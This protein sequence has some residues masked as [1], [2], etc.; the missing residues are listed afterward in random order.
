M[1]KTLSEALG[2]LSPDLSQE[3]FGFDS[4][5]PAPLTVSEQYRALNSLGRTEDAEALRQQ[6]VF[7]ARAPYVLDQPRT[8]G[9]VAVDT[10]ASV[11]Q[12]VNSLATG[13]ASLTALIDPSNVAGIAA[14]QFG[15]LL[16]SD[17]V[18]AIGSNLQLPTAQALAE[19]A[20][21][22]NAVQD[23]ITPFQSEQTQ[24]AIQQTQNEI[25]LA[26]EEN[27]EE[28]S[29]AFDRELENLWDTGKAYINNP[30]AAI[31]L[32][33]QQIPQLLAGA[34]VGKLATVATRSQATAAATLQGEERI[35]A[36]IAANKARSTLAGR[37]QLA[38]ITSQE[39]G[40]AVSATASQILQTS[41]EDLEANS[42]AYREYIKQ[43]LSPENARELVALRGGELA[44]IIQAP[45][46]FSTGRVAAQFETQPFTAA[47]STIG[48]KVSDAAKNIGKELAEE[49]P[50][51]TTGQLAQN[52]GVQQT[53]DETQELTEGL[54][55]A[56][57]E[58]AVGA[59]T[60]TT[61]AQTPTVAKTVATQFIPVAG[62]AAY[63]VGKTGIQIPA[64]IIERFAERRRTTNQDAQNLQEDSNNASTQFEQ[65]ANQVDEVFASSGVG[66][67]TTSTVQPDS[68]TGDNVDIDNGNGG[69][70]ETTD[71]VSSVPT[72]TESNIFSEEGRNTIQAIADTNAPTARKLVDA[73]RTLDTLPK[74]ATE[75]RRAL[76]IYAADLVGE[77]QGEF[78][79]I[80]TQLTEGSGNTEQLTNQAN[81]IADLLN[82]ER[83]GNLVGQIDEM[84]VSDEEWDTVV[85]NL[86]EVT[87]ENINSEE[88][89][90]ALLTIKN[91]SVDTPT[92]VTPEQYDYILNH[93]TSLTPEQRST[94]ETK[95]EVAQAIFDSN[96]VRNN[97]RRESRAGFQSINE[98]A[99]NIFTAIR[100]NLPEVATQQLT[101]LRR[102]AETAQGRAAAHD[103]VASTL[104]RTPGAHTDEM[105]KV[106]GYFRLDNQGNI[107]RTSLQFVNVKSENGLNNLRA[108]QDDANAVTNAFNVLAAKYP[109][110]GATEITPHVPTWETLLQPTTQQNAVAEETIIEEPNVTTEESTN[111]EDTVEPVPEESEVET[112]TTP[113]TQPQ[114]EI[115][116]ETA[117][118]GDNETSDGETPIVRRESGISNAFSE[119]TQ[120]TEA[121]NT[122]TTAAERS[123]R[124][125]QLTKSFT[126]SE[127][128][129][130]LTPNFVD[131]LEVTYEDAPDDLE[132]LIDPNAEFTKEQR[133]GI[134][135]Y[136][137]N[138]RNMMN[139]MNERLAEFAK[140]N[141][142]V[143]S[144]TSNGGDRPAWA[145]GSNKALF[146]TVID[147]ENITY[148]NDLLTAL[149]MSGFN[150]LLGND[151]DLSG[152]SDK[153]I[154]DI[155]GINEQL[156][157]ADFRNE[158]VNAGV[159]I[160]SV[161]DQ[162]ASTLER[163]A[164][165]QANNNVS[166]S[167]GR[168]ITK[169]MAQELLA[170]LRDSGI[171]S[172]TPFE[173][174]GTFAVSNFVKVNKDRTNSL[175]EALRNQVDIADKLLLTEREPRASIGSKIRTVAQNVNG[176]TPQ[177][178]PT[179]VKNA[180]KVLQDTPYF[181]NVAYVNLINALTDAN[182]SQYAASGYNNEDGL[183]K[184]KAHESSLLGKNQGIESAS[185]SLDEHLLSIEEYAQTNGIDV[186]DVPTYFKFG[187]DS[188]GRQ[189]MT[190]SHNPQSS[191]YW[192]EA[193]TAAKTTVDLNNDQHVRELFLHL[194]QGL[195]IKVDKKNNDKAIAETRERLGLEGDTETV[196]PEQEAI[197]AMMNGLSE[198][199]DVW[200]DEDRQIVANAVR[201]KG[202]KYQHTLLQAAKY[203]QALSDGESTIDHFLTFEVDGVTDGPANSIVH[204]VMNRVTTP[205]LNTLKKVGWLINRP[206]TTSNQI[207]GEVP[208]LYT[209]VAERATKMAN[210]VKASGAPSQ[211]RDIRLAMRLMHYAGL[212][213]MDT[214]AQEVTLSR[215]FAKAGV[216]PAVYG[217]GAASI[218]ATY[219]GEYTKAFYKHLS[220]VLAGETLNS[221]FV[222]AL[223]SQIADANTLE[224][225]NR[226]ERGDT[227]AIVNFEIS[228]AVLNQMSE[229]FQ[230]VM[231]DLVFEAIDAETH[232][233]LSQNRKLASLAQIQ[234]IF[235]RDAYKKTY[236]E[237]R[238]QKIESG[239]L[240]P[241]EMLSSS[242][243]NEI[244]TSLQNI[245]P[246]YSN[247]I[248]GTS[249]ATGMYMSEVNRNSSGDDTKVTKQLVNKARSTALDGSLESNATLTDIELPGV[250]MVPLLVISSG[251]AS[252]MVNY[253]NDNPN[254]TAQ[255]VYDG[256][257]T[258][259]G[260][261]V[262][263]SDAINDAVKTGWEEDVLLRA[264]QAFG[265]AKR[266]FPN[267]E[268]LSNESVLELGKALLK[269]KERQLPIERQ[270]QLIIQKINEREKELAAHA[271]R[272]KAVR[273]ALLEVK[274]NISHMGGVDSSYVTGNVE[275]TGSDEDIA[276]AIQQRADEIYQGF[277]TITQE[278]DENLLQAI[279]A[280]GEAV[281][282]NQILDANSLRA[283]LLNHKFGG[284][285]YRQFLARIMVKAIPQETKL[286]FGD[287]ESIN[288]LQAKLFPDVE[289]ILET[290]HGRQIGNYIFMTQ[291][292]P[293]TLLHETVHTVLAKHI[294]DYFTKGSSQNTERANA[295]RALDRIMSDFANIPVE[296]SSLEDITQLNLMRS[297][298]KNAIRRGD[299]ATA[300]N[301]FVA[302]TLS[303]KGL[304]D[305]AA[306]NENT[307]EETRVEDGVFR[308]LFKGVRRWLAK[309][310]GVPMRKDFQSYLESLT[311]QFDAAIYQAP[312]NENSGNN[313][314]SMSDITD[315]LSQDSDSEY[316]SVLA[317]TIKV[318]DENFGKPVLNPAERP[319]YSVNAEIGFN[320]KYENI[321]A[322]TDWFQAQGFMM[323][324]QERHAFQLLQSYF[325]SGSQ[326][327]TN[328]LN[329]MS[330]LFEYLLPNLS[331][332][333]FMINPNSTE[334]SD[335][336]AAQRMY[337]AIANPSQFKEHQLANFAAL[338]ISNGHLQRVLSKKELPK[339]TW[340]KGNSID[341]RLNHFSNQLIQNLA[342]V[343]INGSRSNDVNGQI[344]ILSQKIATINDGSKSSIIQKLEAP[345]RK[346]D[347]A[348]A[349]RVSRLGEVATDTLARRIDDG[350]NETNLDIAKNF[351]LAIA[352]LANKEG[353]AIEAIQTMVNSGRLWRPVSQLINEMIGTTETNSRIMTLLQQAKNQVSAVRQEVK[354]EV[355]K[356][357]AKKFTRK[358]ETHEHIALRKV[359]GESDLQILGSAF[360]LDTLRDVLANRG[361]LFAE[362]SEFRQNIRALPNGERY[363]AHAE[364]LTDYMVTKETKSPHL[365]RNAYAIASLVGLGIQVNNPETY[366]EEI[367]QFVT[368]LVLDKM[369][370]SDKQ[371]VANLINTER[372]GVDFMFTYLRGLA[373]AERNKQSRYNRYNS[374]KG[375]IPESYTGSRKL[376]VTD[377]VRGKDLVEKY[378]YTYLGTGNYS[379]RSGLGY[380]FTSQ[381]LTSTYTQ[382][383]IQNVEPL[384]AGVD[385][386]SGRSRDLKGGYLITNQSGIQARLTVSRN[387]ANRGNHNLTNTQLLPVFDSNGMVTAY[388]APIP[389][390]LR[391]QHLAPEN[392]FFEQIATWHSRA[393]EEQLAHT[394]NA[395]VSKALADMWNNARGLDRNSFV[396]LLESA[397]TSEVDKRTWNSLPAA[398][399]TQ[400]RNAFGDDPIMI[401]RDVLDNALGYS[402]FNIGSV[403]TGE[404]DLPKSVQKGARDLAVALLG[405]NAPRYLL[406]VERGNQDIVS[407]TK[408]WIVVRSVVVGW[409][410]ILSNFA[411]LKMHNVTYG[412]IFKGQLAKLKEVDDFMRNRKEIIDL[413][414]E[415]QGNPSEA[416]LRKIRRLTEANNRMSI[417]PLIANGELPTVAEGMTIEDD[418]S[419]R[420]GLG[421]YIDKAF[422]TLPKGISK[423]LQ[424]ALIAK[425]TPINSAL[426]RM[427]TYSDLV[428]KAVLFDKLTLQDGFTTQQALQFIQDEFVNYDANPGRTRSYL[429]SMGLTWFTN[430]K[431][432]IQKTN[433]RL[434]RDHP[435]SALTVQGS[436]GQ[437]GLDTPMDANIITGNN[438]SVFG[439]PL[440]ALEIPSLHPVVQLLN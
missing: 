426:N 114:E 232:G 308:K 25:Q 323:N 121:F 337:D 285:K 166:R 311:G 244:L 19:V 412:D 124:S 318:L 428:A 289:P 5:T 407:L 79:N 296:H 325:H 100:N 20:D 364:A 316:S 182:N 59:L 92:D 406:A 389:E 312:S 173:L 309:I 70:T 365:L 142:V 106:D 273:M 136:I 24:T 344:N 220:D 44:G 440:K 213:E 141:K 200:T 394:F 355:P 239:E 248:T 343:F 155:L 67:E 194:A 3:A 249:K 421:G 385:P 363:V 383:A 351:G 152:M 259:L 256:L 252:M 35:A 88:V 39:A 196:T 41:F 423:S 55:Q 168:T 274:S 95:R 50:Q 425:N 229:D 211:V 161:I 338:A 195:G 81:V 409:R 21:V 335:I 282:G 154:A 405:K 163:Y 342:N 30:L 397:K 271:K 52:I 222:T 302:W 358:L 262:Q 408:D 65:T 167:Y 149:T 277:G 165:M 175:T 395:D 301:E 51:S 404:T 356:V 295:I 350:Q 224:Q 76:G 306:R 60:V 209:G 143:E 23:V 399:K 307:N 56:A 254:L 321:L 431:L 208:D 297:Q 287:L 322:A 413:Q 360:T 377:Q 40:G 99:N 82:H 225:L 417:A 158:V 228:G 286:V 294:N 313:E 319:N 156:L 226:I 111:V 198:G 135:L 97:I 388:E 14:S 257:D 432:K 77:L 438:S 83:I 1:A 345:V 61:A 334:Q 10:G 354:R 160:T 187:M 140:K 221:G 54:G 125:N 26:Q 148:Q 38:S 429:E 304:N 386:I 132:A 189:R 18:R 328:A 185:K 11:A 420:H 115:E 215:A 267:I 243:E 112:T 368:L 103:K 381:N 361:R 74:D 330:K 390:A 272:N 234:A 427:L 411:Q 63:T 96:A 71:I 410:N 80:N 424:Y 278:H 16:D 122:A 191:K 341:A 31:D 353:Q 157:T 94:L 223:R 84:R 34:V 378:G 290:Q 12:G 414:L 193:I 238:Q 2:D 315:Y 279:S 436:A 359:L 391:Q 374:Y 89:Q 255:N 336:D 435:I 68:T 241:N 245:A 332:E 216:T 333:D 119:L 375:Y 293:E 53:A 270:K 227:Q 13:I 72:N 240:A 331:R 197:A 416:N 188:N 137:D 178:V 129:T 207:Y 299:R 214:E 219:V 43:G 203:L 276:K 170:T 45:L 144:F 36:M 66:Q 78:N 206:D 320:E 176:K 33:V 107:D 396:N 418:E 246:I 146:A 128:R 371:V 236:E 253:F 93:D 403:F 339:A 46:A 109:E 402:N 268:A 422:A 28:F 29:N 190:A 349:S 177:K 437:I 263:S 235:Y 130:N 230:K 387:Y 305:I 201:G 179:K 280:R 326:L 134:R 314:S 48:A 32:G 317:D 42:P 159:P 265:D 15:N 133:N 433:L 6:T 98:Y 87:P 379:E 202:E 340:L 357:L 300:L 110:L 101:E 324:E 303:N 49:I 327:N 151:R 231:G 329:Q 171:I 86:P 288:A 400:L 264:V 205:I 237:L 376:I 247:N 169:A 291:A 199:F 380:Y 362:I 147:G 370:V 284:D 261:M 419:I 58:G 373:Q 352:G 27:A 258:T 298:I 183:P 7:N 366:A 174:E 172:I 251:D 382:G 62:K 113:E 434:L 260:N 127:D 439:T 180:L 348:V 17:T 217:A 104:V 153:Q 392:N 281:N 8:I 164:G 102:F 266:Q 69:T 120:Q 204:M 275:L 283:T 218:S 369:S 292:S 145:L 210:E 212:T 233:S 47:G 85:E 384:I 346:V 116:T 398:V 138:V 22:S 117:P 393:T 73:V 64:T 118:T 367:S 347:A 4:N 123:A 269:W 139:V 401:R 186:G 430:Y 184:N 126:I 57:A 250:R 192:R 90:N 162:I 131:D 150:W 372:E 242:D 310:L 108:I 9:E 91:K 181:V 37:L 415:N 105:T 75:Q